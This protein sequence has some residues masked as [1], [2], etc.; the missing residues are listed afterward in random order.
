MHNHKSDTAD[1]LTNYNDL[2]DKEKRR[3]QIYTAIADSFLDITNDP[4]ELLA[5]TCK[6][7]GEHT[8]DLAVICLISVDGKRIDNT[9]SYHF[10]EKIRNEL[11]NLPVT[12]PM[13][14]AS[15]IIDLVNSENFSLLNLL[16]E[17]YIG[18]L[19]KY[20]FSVS[21]TVPLQINHK[22]IGTINLFHCASDFPY[23]N[24]DQFFL[25][26]IADLL[27]SIIRNSRLYNDKEIQ[28]SEIR[29]RVKNNLQVVSSILSI[30]SDYIK[31]PE[32][33]K[34]F[35]NSLNRVR[36]MSMIHENLYLTGSSSN[37]AFDRYL[38]DAVVFL[39]RTYK[40]N[41]KLIKFSINVAPL[42]LPI[43]ISIT[44][45]LITNELISNA[46]KHAFPDNRAGNIEISFI[47][48][49]QQYNMIVLDDGIGLPEKINVDNSE[50]FG[51]LL[52]NT[53]VDQLN[54]TL[55][56]NRSKGTQFI[57]RFPLNL[58]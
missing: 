6:K 40:I 18:F 3:L 41:P 15:P 53:L 9:V 21:L 52:I 22:L 23:S 50:T 20:S 8:S 14:L 30:Q 27:A 17:E 58:D 57:I 16:S 39:S 35:I 32:S 31:D 34:L 4:K 45:A 47:K 10:D 11:S 54:G 26:K 28:L 51:I 46:I 7:L 33:Y 38:R 24:D 48:V 5:F 1:N 42:F 55:E 12:F 19:D 37:V 49:D 43:D 29:H 44:C 56:I 25:Q 2:L 13:K 36:V